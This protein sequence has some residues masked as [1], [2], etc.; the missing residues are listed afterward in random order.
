MNRLERMMRT[1]LAALSAMVETD[2]SKREGERWAIW[3]RAPWHRP[4]SFSGR[5]GS[6][7]VEVESAE[8]YAYRA[9]FARA[10][11]R[12]FQI[13]IFLGNGPGYR[14]GRG[15]WLGRNLKGEGC[16]RGRVWGRGPGLQ[17]GTGGGRI[18]GWW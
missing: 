4:G 9:S 13:A 14:W 2:H 16:T 15:Y 11:R 1:L 6:V 8:R 5:W 18:P 12:G 10:A 7:Q 17:A 3:L